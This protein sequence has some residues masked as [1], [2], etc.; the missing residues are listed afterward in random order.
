M[1]FNKLHEELETF[2]TKHG[3]Y[4]DLIDQICRAS[5]EHP[6]REQISE[7]LRCERLLRYH[8]KLITAMLAYNTAMRT[9]TLS[10]AKAGFADAAKHLDTL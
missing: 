4:C 10:L 7:K 1:N 5:V 6:T 8:D 3:C 2:E 9:A